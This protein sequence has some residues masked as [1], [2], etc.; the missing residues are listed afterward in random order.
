M[1][2]VGTAYGF[3][4]VDPGDA[5]RLLVGAWTCS[6]R[7]GEFLLDLNDPDDLSDNTVTVLP[8]GKGA[9]GHGAWSPDGTLVAY[10]LAAGGIRVHDLDKPEDSY[11]V[12]TVGAGGPSFTD[13]GSRLFF[14]FQGD[15]HGWDL[16]QMK[17]TTELD[18]NSVEHHGHW[19]ALDVDIDRDRDGAA[20]G[21]D[22]APDDP[23]QH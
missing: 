12:S 15:V 9:S 22:Q 4:R 17:L 18:I 7:I 2:D 11:T 3:P 5:T 14:A 19:V 23:T 21:I 16:T 6:G 1:H 20:N 10:H 8:G 13:D